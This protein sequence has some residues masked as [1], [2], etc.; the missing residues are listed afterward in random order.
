MTEHNKKLAIASP[1]HALG[2]INSAQL[3]TSGI[4]FK[5]MNFDDPDVTPALLDD[6]PS[7]RSTA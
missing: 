7:G 3:T 1:D 6:L 5:S 2:R 4:R